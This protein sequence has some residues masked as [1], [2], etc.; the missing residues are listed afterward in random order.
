MSLHIGI[1]AKDSLTRDKV[2]GLCRGKRI[3]TRVWSHGNLGRHPFWKEN[4]G[5]FDGEWS[6]EIYNRGF[7][8]P[9]YPELNSDDIDYIASIC[10]KY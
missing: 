6:N 9:T 2:L 5:I 7:I 4:Y 1:L 3:E 10:N 8:L